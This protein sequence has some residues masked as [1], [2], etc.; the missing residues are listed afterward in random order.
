MEILFSFLNW[1]SSFSHVDEESGSKMDIHNLATV[2]TPNICYS[3]NKNSG[4][5]DSFLAIEAVH[6]LIECNEAMCEVSCASQPLGRFCID[7]LQRYRKICS[8]S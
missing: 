2:V 3:N 4:M 1:V 7:L 5:D 8:P 6:C